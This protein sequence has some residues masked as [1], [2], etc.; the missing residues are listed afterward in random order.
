MKNTICKIYYV[1]C[2]DCILLKYSK[3]NKSVENSSST[4]KAKSK[5]YRQVRESR[6]SLVL[7]MLGDHSNSSPTTHRRQMTSKPHPKYHYL[8]P[9]EPGSINL[10]LI[11]SSYKLEQALCQDILLSN[12]YL[13]GRLLTHITVYIYI[14][15]SINSVSMT[16]HQVSSFVL[17]THQLG[18][19]VTSQ[20]TIKRYTWKI[21]GITHS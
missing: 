2:R 9:A 14:C 3:F 12:L 13:V 6:L 21:K 11:H 7:H 1:D 4:F 17:F 18:I 19:I 15:Y 5:F 20:S 10:N 16:E 8:C